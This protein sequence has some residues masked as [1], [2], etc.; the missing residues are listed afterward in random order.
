MTAEGQSPPSAGALLRLWRKRRRLSQ[1]ELSNRAQ[2]SSRHLSFV[3]SGRST[4]SRQLLVHLTKTLEIPLRERNR[5]LLAAGY[6]PIYG[7]TPWSSSQLSAVR[8]AVQLVLTGLEPYPALAVD[9]C[10]NLVEANRSVGLMINDAAAELLSPPVNVLRL[11]M[12]PAGLASRISNL[13]QWRAHVLTRLRR[14]VDYTADPDLAALHKEL[15]G[16]PCSD[17]AP[18]TEVPGPHDLVIPLRM[19]VGNQQL[20][21]LSTTTVFGTPQDVTVAELAIESFLPADQ[22][23]ADILTAAQANGQQT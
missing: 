8:E 10:W 5:L 12:H 17:H 3:E 19:Q 7:A 13:G 15:Q 4:P 11:S 16:Y 23:T 14:Q 18:D 22:A 21:L 1:L 6:A 2:I 20:S 9:R